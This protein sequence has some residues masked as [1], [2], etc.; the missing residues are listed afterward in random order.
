MESAQLSGSE[1][2]H[3]RKEL[4]A[5]ISQLR[6]V[7]AQGELDLPRITVI[8]NQS[9]GKSSVVEAISGIKVPRDPGTCTRCPMECRLSSSEDPWSCRISIRHEFDAAGKP[10][11]EVAEVHFCNVKRKDDVELALRRAQFAVLNPHVDPAGVAKMSAAELKDGVPG[12]RTLEFS[13]N[14]IVVAVEGPELTDL[15]FLDLPGVIQNAEKHVVEMVENMVKSHIGGNSLILV[16]LPMTDDIENQK[17]LRLAR[18]QDPHGRRTIGVLTKPDMLGIGSKARDLWL[19]VIE[20]RKHPLHHGYYCTRQPDDSER[21]KN[22][23]TAELRLAE[24]TF[25]ENTAPWSKSVHS[26]RFG[27]DNLVSTL[28]ALLVQIINDQLPFIQQTAA[29]KLGSCRE[30]LNTIPE[31]LVGEPATHILN[32]ITEFAAYIRRHVDGDAQNNAT[33]LIHER[34][35]AFDKFKDAIKNTSPR[36]VARLKSPPGTE[37]GAPIVVDE[38]MAGVQFGAAEMV[39]QGMNVYLSDVRTHINK[40]IT[41]ELPGNIPYSAK[42]SLIIAFQATWLSHVRTCFDAIKQVMLNLL[43]QSVEHQ[44]GRYALLTNKLHA[45]ITELAN[46]CY[47]NCATFLWAMLEVE[48]MPFTQNDHYLQ[49]STDK[50]A[51]RYKD[52]RAGKA[53]VVVGDEPASKKRRVVNGQ[54]KRKDRE[55]STSPVRVDFGSSASSSLGSS[56]GEPFRFGTGGSGFRFANLPPKPDDLRDMAPPPAPNPHDPASFARDVNGPDKMNTLLA[57]LAEAGYA[58]VTPEDLARLRPGDAYETEMKVM[59]EVKGY[60]KCAYKRVIDNIPSLI[61]ARFLRAISNSLQ[62]ELISAFQLGGEG[63]DARCAMYLTEDPMVVAKRDEL[64]A[65]RK[66]LEAV[67]MELHNFALAQAPRDFMLGSCSRRGWTRSFSSFNILFL[68]RDEFSCAIFQHLHASNDVWQSLTVATHPDTRVGR[69]PL[70]VMAESVD[71]PVTAI[72]EQKPDFKS[73]VPPSPFDLHSQSHLLVTASFGRIL[74]PAQLDLFPPAHRLNVH[75]SVLP[76]YRGPAPIQHAILDGRDTTGV[77][78]VRMLK[79]GVDKGPVWGTAKLPIKPQDTFISLRDGLAEVGGEL[80]V[81]VLRDM[82]AGKATSSPQPPESPTRHASAITTADAVLDFAVMSAERIVVLHRAIGH[83]RTLTTWLPN[84]TRLQLH[85]PFLPSGP[86][87]SHYPIPSPV[88]G[89]ARFIKALRALLV[90]CAD[91][92]LVAIPRVKKEKRPTMLEAREFWNGVLPSP[93]CMVNGDVRFVPE[94][95][96]R[97]R[98]I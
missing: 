79:R 10:L 48:Q 37:K 74:T 97:G 40:S 63:A 30:E 94:N 25:F 49:S 70:R 6:A 86:L 78:V 77:S 50:W 8:G 14:V 38:D 92:S 65:R 72:P 56:N 68:G 84:G 34:N 1:Y 61:D 21:S 39:A 41:R 93:V 26:N 81:Q 16:A 9:A 91:G 46:K 11:R 67:Q 51:A 47:D 29:A 80:L 75:G 66:R 17:A 60:F 33:T 2:A 54:E 98:E 88:P 44:F 12:G 32:L 82:L 15:V 87:P 57:A 96:I 52:E 18:E 35:A 24:S 42:K 85:D 73:W 76:A 36:F 90:R 55:R 4:L 5:L 45:T 19:D 59:A 58:G 69:S 64:M 53:R 3:R 83:Q 89:S 13:R 43:L 23:S 95:E 20:G 31:K 62:K 22:P 27:M 28:S 7:G 71:V